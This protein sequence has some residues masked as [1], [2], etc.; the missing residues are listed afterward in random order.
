MGGISISST[1]VLGGISYDDDHYPTS[2]ALGHTPWVIRHGAYTLHMPWVAYQFQA[3]LRWVAYH[4]ILPWVA[5]QF[6]ALFPGPA[7]GGI[8][9][10]ISIFWTGGE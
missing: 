2:Y 3:L 9:I 6:E 4:M 10:S 1:I 8:S 5:Y 7:H